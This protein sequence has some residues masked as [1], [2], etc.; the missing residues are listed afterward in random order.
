MVRAAPTAN[1]IVL[2]GDGDG[3]VDAAGAGSMDGGSLVLQ[4]T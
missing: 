4:A 3:L 2:A 1:P